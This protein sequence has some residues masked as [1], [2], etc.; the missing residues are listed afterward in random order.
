[1]YTFAYMAPSTQTSFILNLSAGNFA[2]VTANT[3]AFTNFPYS[4]ATIYVKDSTA[5]SWIINGNSSWGTSFS[6]SNVLIR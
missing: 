1:M 4:K 5:Q 3:A 2:N 6:A